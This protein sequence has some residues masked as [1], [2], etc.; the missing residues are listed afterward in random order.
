[1]FL[2][3]QLCFIISQ[4]LDW[5]G[6]Q[7]IPLNSVC[8]AF[9]FDDVPA[10]YV[11]CVRACRLDPINQNGFATS[12]DCEKQKCNDINENPDFSNCTPAAN[13]E[14]TLYT[15]NDCSTASFSQRCESCVSSGCSFC[16]RSSDPDTVVLEKSAISFC[17]DG[18]GNDAYYGECSSDKGEDVLKMYVRGLPLSIQSLYIPTTTHH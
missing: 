16:D 1:M 9:T 12:C 6:A 17:W 15:D 18:V 5:V 8:N 3:L 7:T 2:F 10:C 14:W 11:D 13:E 4:Y